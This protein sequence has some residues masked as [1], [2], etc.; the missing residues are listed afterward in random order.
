[1]R[2]ILNNIAVIG[3]KESEQCVSDVVHLRRRG[4]WQVRNFPFMCLERENLS[5]IRAGKTKKKISSLLP[6]QVVCTSLS[7]IYVSHSNVRMFSP[8]GQK[9]RK[10][11]IAF[12]KILLSPPFFR[13]VDFWRKFTSGIIMFCSS[14]NNNI[15]QFPHSFVGCSEYSLLYETQIFP[16]KKLF[17]DEK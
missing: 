11:F 9:G 1:M 2:Y 17:R 12:L 4:P 7:C 16:K 6:S 5:D 13:C 14:G 8:Q 10:S 3:L 15:S